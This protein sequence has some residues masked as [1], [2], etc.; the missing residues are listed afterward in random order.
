MLDVILLAEGD[1]TQTFDL[2]LG[3]DREHLMHTALGIVT[4]VSILPT[5]K[6]PPHVG[7]TGWLF[8]LDAPNLVLTGM[9]PAPDGADGVIARLFECVG[10]NGSAELRSPRDP[11]RAGTQDAR[12]TP[13]LDA[14]LYGDAASF[15]AAPGDLLHLRVD[16][17]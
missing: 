3:L 8:H 15:E 11:I 7:A 4:P 2:A 17:S 14:S 16:F 10:H 13:L 12:G 5:T 1:Q 9:R 6:G